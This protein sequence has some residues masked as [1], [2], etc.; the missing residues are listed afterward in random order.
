M[1]GTL[2]PAYAAAR[3]S[4][5]ELSGPELF[6][7]E[8]RQVADASPAR[9]AEYATVRRVARACLAE[10]GVGPVPLVR[11]AGGAPRWPAGTVGSLTHCRGYRAAAAARSR[12]TDGLGIDAEPCA[13]LPARVLSHVASAA[14]RAHLEKLRAAG[15]D[16]PWCRL[17]FSAKEAYYKVWYP[18]MGCWLGFDDAE[19]VFEPGCGSGTFEV[20]PVS[21]GVRRAR[22]ADASFDP[23][24]TGFPALRGRWAAGAGVVVTALA[25]P[26]GSLPRPPVR[27][28]TGRTAT[29]T[30]R[31]AQ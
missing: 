12:D 6:E 1:I 3:E 14:E 23:V 30:L 10:L 13:P 31:W 11:G 4:V 18:A 28:Y 21:G 29:G 7:A 17:L 20:R 9:R 26:T 2:L 15:S 22:R 25:A 19:V 5:C 27:P 16:V 8:R 24:A